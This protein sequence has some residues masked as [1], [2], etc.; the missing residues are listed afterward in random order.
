MRSPSPPTCDGVNDDGQAGENDTLTNIDNLLG[1]S[2]ADTLTLGAAPGILTGNDGG[3]TL[4]AGTARRLDDRRRQRRRQRRGAQL[5][6]GLDH[7]RRRRR[8]RQGRCERHLAADCDLQDTTAPQTTISK[9]PKK[10]WYKASKGQGEFRFQSSE[11]GSTF[12]CRVDGGGFHPCTSPFH[13]RVGRARHT[14]R[15]RAIDAAGNVD[16]T[17]A[18]FSWRVVKPKHH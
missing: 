7:L 14:F 11:P 12:E 5:G 18:V 15:V 4:G 2:A 17:P 9:T 8:P 16:A 3:D 1:G 13:R 10:G 6:R